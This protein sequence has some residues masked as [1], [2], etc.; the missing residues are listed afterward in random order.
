MA[1]AGGGDASVVAC[2]ES[3]SAE[4]PHDVAQ[5]RVELHVLVARDAGVRCLAAGVRAD[6][7][8]DDALAEHVGVVER[9][10]GDAE[11]G[12]GATRVLPRLVGTTAAR[13]IDIAA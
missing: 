12:G 8:V 7:M 13:R 11:G 9:V 2:R 5:Q 10:E 1:T 3:I 6:E 4:L